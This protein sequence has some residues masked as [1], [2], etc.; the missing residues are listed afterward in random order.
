MARYQ[1]VSNGNGIRRG[2]CQTVPKMLKKLLVKD[3]TL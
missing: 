1:V 2:Q 3:L